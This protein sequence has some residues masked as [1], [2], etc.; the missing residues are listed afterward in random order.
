MAPTIAVGG[1]ST[2]W[3]STVTSAQVRFVNPAPASD[4][5][6]AA[7]TFG[8]NVGSRRDLPVDVDV[9]PGLTD[10]VALAGK[11][12]AF[13]GRIADDLL[14]LDRTAHFPNAE[15]EREYN[16]RHDDGKFR[17]RCPRTA[18]PIVWPADHV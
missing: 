4:W 17:D 6:T 13:S 3:K 1:Q 8:L 12:G 2:N 16:C 10:R 7:F 11:A 15:H 14:D 9:G 18:K 5:T